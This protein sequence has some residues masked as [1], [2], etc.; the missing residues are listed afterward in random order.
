MNSKRKD[1]SDLV[2]SYDGDSAIFFCSSESQPT[3]CFP[4]PEDAGDD[5]L[6]KA[7]FH[8]SPLSTS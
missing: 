3:I 7:Q 1:K 2:F 8:F 6:D 5:S 4:S